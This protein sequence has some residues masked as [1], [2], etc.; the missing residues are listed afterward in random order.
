MLDDLSE[1]SIVPDATTL[2]T[3]TVRDEGDDVRDDFNDE[4]KAVIRNW[5]LLAEF[6]M[7]L[8]A[9]AFSGHNADH[10]FTECLE[11]YF[12][13][14]FHSRGSCLARGHSA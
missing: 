12:A 11:R 1:L 4:F 13:K 10:E 7:M 3:R 5:Q 8:A 9:E 6:I 14:H 2:R